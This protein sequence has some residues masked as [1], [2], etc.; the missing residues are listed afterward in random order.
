MK[1]NTHL[2]KRIAQIAGIFSFV[3]CI[4][5][6]VN[7][8]QLKK[9]DPVESKAIN[10]LIERL[11]ENPNDA[12]LREEVRMLDLLSRKA[13][14]TNQ[15]QVRTGGY[16][17]LLGISLL[18]IA[19]QIIKST[20]KIKP[21]LAKT[22]NSVVTQKKTR[23]WVAISG[24]GI[25]IIALFFAFLTHNELST[26]FANAAIPDSL[27][28]KTEEIEETDNNQIIIADSTFVEN[29]AETDSIDNVND[30]ILPEKLSEFPTYQEIIK[31]FPTF[32]GYGG[33]GIAHHKNIPVK[34]NGATGEN[35]C[36]KTVIPLQGYNSPVIW[37]DKIFLSGANANKREIYCID[38]LS[39]KIIWT[40]NITN[41][42]GSPTISPSVTDD[43]G[44]AA[45]TLATDGRKVYAVFS[46]GDI[47]AYN[48]D[49]EKV[50]ARNLGATG[51]HYG[52]SS[53]LM[54]LQNILIVQY[55][56][57]TSPKLMGLSTKNGS[58]IW[59]TPRKVKV[60]WASPVV[61]YTG[62]Q[63]EI[64]V[65]ADPYVASYN[66]YSGKE[67]WR[68][69]CIYG[70]VGP[71]VAYADSIVFSVNEYANLSAIKIGETPKILWENM[72]YLSDVPSPIATKKYLFLATSYGVVVCYNAKT[73][74]QYWEHEFNNGFYSSPM[75]VEGKI[76]L[77]DMGGI[78]H[79]FS[80][81]NKYV[82]IGT[83]QLGET[84]MTTP[85]F[86][87]GHIYIRG[88]KNL[89]CIG[90]K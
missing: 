46:N 84:T 1:I 44:H 3:V 41:V 36:W 78:M 60:S 8:I 75:L 5:L 77:I 48:M 71:S 67:N 68:I 17:L 79:I 62:K 9:I 28:I 37:G 11:N 89:Y 29:T 56:T 12:Q 85:A 69:D 25:V 63:T 66:P 16:L 31:N 2:W 72:D 13:Y 59:S 22:D 64:F 35:I 18:I 23:R 26:T 32:R 82:S 19:L 24:T 21:I 30:T 87:D 38:R 81:S 39:G 33:N 51:N 74:E 10:S 4:T 83:A 73:G 90:K 20:E 42:P 14:F 27:K 53:S 58:T 76:Y 57:K 45:A 86:A 49:G 15:W 7:Y 54:L 6:I 50:W 34:W 40:A 88:E 70:E 52:H 61:A 55:D 43:T 65:T 47:V 80:A